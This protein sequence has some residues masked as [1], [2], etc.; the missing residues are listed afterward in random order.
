MAYKLVV[1]YGNSRLQHPTI[2]FNGNF[3]SVKKFDFKKKKFFLWK[4][5]MFFSCFFFNLFCEEFYLNVKIISFL[6]EFPEGFAEDR[7]KIDCSCKFISRTIWRFLKEKKTENF[8]WGVS[9]CIIGGTLAC[10]LF[11]SLKNERFLLPREANFMQ[12]YCIGKNSNEGVY[13][14]VIKLYFEVF[15]SG[16]TLTV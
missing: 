7:F 3:L 4:P 10:P 6:V 16:E 14:I 12:L 8:N 5:R 2:Q 1:N 11:R 9:F 13:S 15:F